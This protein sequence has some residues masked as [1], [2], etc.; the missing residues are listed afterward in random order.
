MTTTTDT[1]AADRV[2][3]RAAPPPEP[4]RRG[5]LPKPGTR[6]RVAACPPHPCPR[7]PFSGS[8]KTAARNGAHYAQD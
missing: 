2:H 3:A 7:A 8:T 4:R 1:A 6:R 5:S